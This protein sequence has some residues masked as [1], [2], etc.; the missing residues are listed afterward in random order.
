MLL[1]DLVVHRDLP[2]PKKADEAEVLRGANHQALLE[3]ALSNVV[4]LNP[5][6]A[7]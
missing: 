7:L 3:V 1:P 4:A 2:V 5:M 6:K